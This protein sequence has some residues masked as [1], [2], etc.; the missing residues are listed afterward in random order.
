MS[1][2]TFQIDPNGD[3]I[4]VLRNPN[5]PFAVWDTSLC[6]GEESATKHGPTVDTLGLFC[7]TPKFQF[8]VN[9]PWRW[10]KVLQD[11]PEST[12]P[13]VNDDWGTLRSRKAAKKK[14]NKVKKSLLFEDLPEAPPNGDHEVPSVDFISAGPSESSVNH[15]SAF[16][17]AEEATEVTE[18]YEEPHPEVSRESEPEADLATEP[19]APNEPIAR[20]LVSSRHLALASRYF[21]AKLSGSWKEAAVKHID[22]CYHMDA[23][24]WDSEALLILMKVIHGKTRSVPRQMDLEMLAKLAVLV[25][26]YDCHE[27]IEIYC[28]AWIGHLRNKLPVDYGRDMVL[29]LL[30]SHVFQQ[31]DIFQQMTQVA[32]LKSAG[33]VRTMELPIP[34]SLVGKV[35]AFDSLFIVA[36]IVA[37][38]VDWRRQDAVEFILEVLHRLLDSFR[39]ETAG[40]SFE[41]SSILLGALTKEM[42]KHTLLNPKPAKPYSGYSIVDTEKIVRAFR[43][44]VWSSDFSYRHSAKH[45]CNLLSM[46]DCYLNADFDK[47]KTGF[48]LS[49]VFMQHINGEGKRLEKGK[50]KSCY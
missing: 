5:A 42:D 21:S 17:E 34:S 20:Y 45:S 41:C 23:T 8:H 25:D 43:S 36:E 47:N 7:N 50:T 30:I 33:P 28:P 49:E 48:H 4:L 3:V 10:N 9:D 40:C 2:E 12:L 14:K 6:S 29:W 39:N 37:E 46:I 31:D 32:V 15:A 35:S 26:Y 38:L 18:A 11:E 13:D 19:E 16:L 24:D 27:V 44:P 22:G 1:E